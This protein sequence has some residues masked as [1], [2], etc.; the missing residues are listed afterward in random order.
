MKYRHNQIRV[1]GLET[2]RVQT[3]NKTDIKVGI[4]RAKGKDV[5]IIVLE[6]RH[7][8]TDDKVQ[9]V[10]E[11]LGGYAHTLEIHISNP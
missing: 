5:C 3:A 8:I 6:E 10:R 1:L 4:K 2:G 7:Q 9:A 11:A